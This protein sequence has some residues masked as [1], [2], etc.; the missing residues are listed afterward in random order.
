[1]VDYLVITT[2]IQTTKLDKYLFAEYVFHDNL[3]IIFLALPFHI[4]S[5]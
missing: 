1:V 5:V 4:M 3:Y 2:T